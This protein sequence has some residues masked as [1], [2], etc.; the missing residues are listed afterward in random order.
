MEKLRRSL[1]FTGAMQKVKASESGM[2]AVTSWSRFAS[3]VT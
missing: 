3:L 2:G 1:V